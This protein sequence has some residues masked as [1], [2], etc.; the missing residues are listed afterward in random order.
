MAGRNPVRKLMPVW[1]IGVIALSTTC[2]LAEQADTDNWSISRGNRA[3][4][5]RATGELADALHLKWTFKAN[6][7][8]RSSAAISRGR[9]FVGCDNGYVYAFDLGTGKELWQFITGDAVEASPC[10]VDDTVY[11]GSADYFLYA[12]NVVDGKLRWKYE[13]GERVLGGANWV[14]GADDKGV[15]IIVGSYDSLLHCVD[16]LSGKMVWTYDTANYI[17]GTPAVDGDRIVFG[18][19]DALVHVVSASTGRRAG[20]VP[21]GSYIAGS[22]AV[23]GDLA[24]LGHMGNQLLCVNL[25]RQAVVWESEDHELPFFSSPAIDK[26]RMIIGGRDRTL[27][28]VSRADGK[29]LWTFAAR[30][31]ID[32]SPVIC[33]DK[34]VF[35]AD[36]GRLYMVRLA[37]GKKVWSYQ[38]GES[39][40][41][42]PAVAGGMVVISSEDGVVSAFASGPAESPAKKVE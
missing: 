42:T 9:V 34:V 21:A 28:C 24:F 15:R 31:K 2:A 12:L 17:N 10:V 38:V 4:H 1:A 22:V 13:T 26:T 29:S 14:N 39:I 16:A 40:T 35:G 6:E 27:H 11:V 7:A 37:D 19:C 36:D 30:G 33:G 8:I 3:L 23:D 5:G 20:A 25:K 32:S 18:G 41:T